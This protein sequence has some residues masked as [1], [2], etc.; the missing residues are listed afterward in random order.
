MILLLFAAV[1][2]DPIVGTWEGSSLCQVRPSPCHDEHVIYH[3]TSTG[4]RRYRIDAYKLVGGQELFTG[5]LDVR[6]DRSGH[7][8]AG[9]NRDRAGVD[10][11]WL[12]TVDGKHITGRALTAVSGHVFRIIEIDRH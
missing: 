12:F 2:T 6:L 7:E 9:S 5:P 1:A 11:P 10:H 3:I 8:L 4:Q